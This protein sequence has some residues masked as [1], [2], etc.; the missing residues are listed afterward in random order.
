MTAATG[1]AEVQAALPSLDGQRD[2]HGHAAPTAAQQPAPVPGE[3]AGSD[4]KAQSDFAS[5]SR[6]TAAAA[7]TPATAQPAADQF[8]FAA[9]FGRIVS[10]L[11]RSAHY[12]HY[13]LSDLEWLVLPPLRSG[14]CAVME[15][16]A[17]GRRAPVAVALWASVSDEVDKRLSGNLNIPIKLRPD[18]WRSGDVLW[19]IDAVGE[20][21]AVP[22]LLRQVE[23]TVFKARE[24]KMRAVDA[25]GRPIVG[26]LNAIELAKGSIQ[27]QAK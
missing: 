16:T 7:A 26:V 19:L 24:V 11:M 4:T 6:N 13:A 12:K 22:H 23:E 9:T 10:V 8:L 25:N 3:R 5:L 21:N 18:E 1:K 20:P 14:Q 2:A 27:I 17:N 15:G